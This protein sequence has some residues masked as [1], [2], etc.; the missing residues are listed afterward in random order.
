MP[1]AN[2]SFWC[3]WLMLSVNMNPGDN[4]NSGVP[5]KCHLFVRAM[6][7]AS[8]AVYRG[9]NVPGFACRIP[10]PAQVVPPRL[11]VPFN[12]SCFCQA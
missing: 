4:Q 5:A 2:N 12:I 1:Q 6:A 10:H 11:P 7:L 8:A 3:V 9:S